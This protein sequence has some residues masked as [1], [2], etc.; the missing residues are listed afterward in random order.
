MSSAP[1]TLLV[2]TGLQREARIARGPGVVTVCSGGNALLLQKRL[3][4]LA[5]AAR[6]GSG[7]PA[8]GGVLSFGLAGGLAPH[9]KSGDLVISSSVQCAADHHEAHRG[10]HEAVASAL[11]AKLTAHRGKTAGHDLVLAKTS[12]KDAMHRQTGALAVD[13]ESHIAAAYARAH[14]LPFVAIRA[15]SDCSTRSLPPVAT[16]ALTED[17]SIALRRVIMGLLRDTGQL[18]AM[19]AAGVDSERA[20]ASLRRCRRLLGPLFGLSRADL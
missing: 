2:V 18:P 16:D 19:I 15:I 5:P 12:E 20:F 13:M 10:W 4:A 8:I 11:D 17:G 7:A 3:S 9:L 14:N 6:N 1:P